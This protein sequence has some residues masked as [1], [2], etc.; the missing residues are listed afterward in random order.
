M[1]EEV[2]NIPDIPDDYSRRLS[3]VLFQIQLGRK[4]GPGENSSR[5]SITELLILISNGVRFRAREKISC[6]SPMQGAELRK[7]DDTLSILSSP[8]E[9]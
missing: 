8:S 4:L 2:A 7:Q 3:R 1:E 9:V 6:A 5:V